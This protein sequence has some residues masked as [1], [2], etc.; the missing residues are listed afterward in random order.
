MENYVYLGGFSLVL[1]SL[2]YYINML[3][4]LGDEVIT[5]GISLDKPNSKKLIGD[6]SKIITPKEFYISFDYP[7]SNHDVILYR[8]ADDG[9]NLKQLVKYIS[10]TYKEIYNSEPDPGKAKTKFAGKSYFTENRAESDGFF[11]NQQAFGR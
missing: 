8:D 1:F 5:N 9:F 4:K 3:K 7:F 11:G 10:E 6:S 2:T